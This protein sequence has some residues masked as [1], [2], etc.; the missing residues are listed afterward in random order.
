MLFF[1]LEKCSLVF[2]FDSKH[3]WHYQVD[4]EKGSEV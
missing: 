2:Q 4:Y 1:Q 3:F